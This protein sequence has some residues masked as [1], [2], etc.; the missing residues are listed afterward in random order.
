L[1]VPDVGQVAVALGVVQPVADDEQVRDLEPD[2]ADG[3]VDALL[4]RLAEQRA[5][6]SRTRGCG[7]ERFFS[8]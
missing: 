3:D 7:P 8:R 2:V 1:S 5:S 6:T 4:V